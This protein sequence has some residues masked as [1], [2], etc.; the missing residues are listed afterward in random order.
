MA[1]VCSCHGIVDRV[2]RE[3]IASGAATVEDVIADCAAGGS[4]GGCVPVIETL[5][6]VH[7]ETHVSLTRHQVA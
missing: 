7:R 3:S 4:C 5:L 6:A 1:F 2:V